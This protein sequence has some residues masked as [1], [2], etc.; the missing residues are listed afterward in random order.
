MTRTA[1]LSFEEVCAAAAAQQGQDIKALKHA[2]F[3]KPLSE[4]KQM[5]SEWGRTHAELQ[6]RIARVRE[7]MQQ[8][9]NAGLDFDHAARL[10]KPFLDQLTGDGAGRPGILPT[11]AGAIE[12][13]IAAIEHFTVRQFHEEQHVWCA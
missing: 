6:G 13:A 1:S 9:V 8:A 2:L 11:T 4:L 3:A 7:R 12:R 10:A 5:Q